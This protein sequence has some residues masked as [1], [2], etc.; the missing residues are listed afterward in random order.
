MDTKIQEALTFLTYLSHTEYK[1]IDQHGNNI[2]RKGIDASQHHGPL[3]AVASILGM[4]V[5]G[6]WTG[7]MIIDKMA[8]KYP[9]L[10]EILTTARKW[11]IVYTGDLNFKQMP[12]EKKA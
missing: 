12:I 11:Q 1:S 10:R 9:E 6:D 4:S 8:R 5:G 3:L 2:T 7:S